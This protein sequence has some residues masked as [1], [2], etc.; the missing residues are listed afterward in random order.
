MNGQPLPRHP[1]ALSASSLSGSD[2]KARLLH[3]IETKQRQCIL[4]QQHANRECAEQPKN[5]RC[6][7]T[8]KMLIACYG[9]DF[10]SSQI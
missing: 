6:I 7:E 3:R 10:A 5:E 2:W 4:L 9:Y 1:S 8:S